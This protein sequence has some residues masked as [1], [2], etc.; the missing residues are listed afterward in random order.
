MLI[1][2]LVFGG[3][4]VPWI[5]SLSGSSESVVAMCCLV[6]NSS[7]ILRGIANVGSRQKVLGPDN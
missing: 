5:V 4:F 6:G 3:Y 7:G 2:G 1:P